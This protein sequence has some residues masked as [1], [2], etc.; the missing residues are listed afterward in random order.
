MIHK[1]L[2]VGEVVRTVPEAVEVFEEH[3]LT[4]CA[5]CYVTLF[6]TLERAAGY[7]AI[8]DLDRMIF[9]LQALVE[10]LQQVRDREEGAHEGV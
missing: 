6:S 4:F 1:G 5:G 10:R 8:K 3:E 9:D 2:T 7:A